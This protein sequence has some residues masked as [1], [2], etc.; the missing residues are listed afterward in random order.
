MGSGRS[1]YIPVIVTRCQCH[2]APVF[3]EDTISVGDC[4]ASEF[5]S[6]IPVLCQIKPSTVLLKGD[7][8]LRRTVR[9]EENRTDLII[10]TLYGWTE[11]QLT[12]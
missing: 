12:C 11:K 10:C 5:L 9:L 8:S 7:F 3:K 1:I 2:C 4:D 6:L